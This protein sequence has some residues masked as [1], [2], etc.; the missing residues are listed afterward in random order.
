MV[1]L[2]VSIVSVTLAFGG[3]SAAHAEVRAPAAGGSAVSLAAVPVAVVK[4][5]TPRGGALTTWA[6]GGS[7]RLAQ[8]RELGAIEQLTRGALS[9]RG[10]AGEVLSDVLGI[11]R[12]VAPRE[13]RRVQEG[14]TPHAEGDYR[15]RA[16]GSGSSFG[17]AAPA[18]DAAAAAASSAADDAAAA[19][20]AARPQNGAAPPTR[21]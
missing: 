20:G 8:L 13:A 7:V 4:G 5:A 11:A 9:D 14:R 1:N 15:G 18:A 2:A 19:A 16:T 12:N 6:E 17:G 3:A 10:E 21:K